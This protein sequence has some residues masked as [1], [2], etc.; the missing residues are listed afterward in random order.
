MVTAVVAALV[1]VATSFVIRGQVDDVFATHSEQL[2]AI[3]RMRVAQVAAWQTER[4]ADAEVTVGSPL[5][6]GVVASWRSRPDDPVLRSEVETQLRVMRDAY[7][8]QDVLL[9]APDGRLLASAGPDNPI[10]ER[11]TLSVVKAVLAPGASLAFAT[12]EHPGEPWHVHVDIVAAFRDRSGTAIA[13]LVLRSDPAA[14]LYPQLLD[15]PTGGTTGE[16]L[17]VERH[18]VHVVFLSLLRL[19]GPAGVESIDVA[20]TDVP[21]VQA[22]LGRVGPFQGLDYRGVP[23]VADLRPVPGSDWYII[24]KLDLAE[25]INAA[26]VDSSLIGVL[27]GFTVLLVGSMV[28]LIFLVRQRRILRRLTEAQRQRTAAVEHYDRL[29]ARARDAFLLYDPAGR[30]VEANIAA[31]ALYGYPRDQLVELTVWDLRAPETRTLTDRDWAAGGMANGV[32]FETVHQRQDGTRISVEISSRELE[33]NGQAYR[34]SIIRDITDRKVAEAALHE[35][36]DELR[37]WSAVTIGRED[38]ILALKREVNEL[39]QAQGSP[40]RYAA[41]PAPEDGSSDG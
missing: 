41:E 29:F 40:P 4:L 8:Y 31:V 22:V 23:V 33:I 36:L 20:R 7:R 13:V 14:T 38:R 10:L 19:A 11:D 17:L 5:V 35:Q 34:Q 18:G 6:A 15:W 21:A 16:T 25:V 37:R 26:V 39:A 9:A 12:A 24:N 2:A 30:I 1:V 3:G 27:A 32:L 28:G